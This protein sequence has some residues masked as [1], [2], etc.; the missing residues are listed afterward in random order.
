M[1]PVMPD[2]RY[3]L[4][5]AVTLSGSLQ[6]YGNSV[7]IEMR[8]KGAALRAWPTGGGE[9]AWHPYNRPTTRLSLQ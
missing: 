4:Y 3:Q 2:Y 8:S 6:Y 1:D 5:L 7:E 9:G